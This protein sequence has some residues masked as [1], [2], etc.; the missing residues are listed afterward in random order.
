MHFRR[1]LSWFLLP[2]TLA[3]L[4]FADTQLVEQFDTLTLSFAG[5]AT[6]EQA[7]VNP[8]TDTRL[9]VTFTH[10]ERHY[11]IR[12]F[13]AAD[14]HAAET[15]ADSGPIWQVRFT[16]DRIGAWTYT[17]NLHRG[18]DIALS[19]D[20]QVGESL[21]LASPSGHFTVIPSTATG[22]DFRAHGRLIADGGFFRFQDTDN[23]WLK[24][25]TDSPENLLAFIDFDGTYRYRTEARQGE[26]A[27]QTE[28]HSYPTHMADWR[29]GDPTWQNGKGKALIGGLNYLA[30][31]G[32]NVAYFLTMNIG[33]DGKDVWPF[34]DHETFDR[35]D[36]SKL[37]QWEI[38]FQHMS[39]RGIMLHVVTQETENE[40]LLDGGDTGRL[41]QLYYRELIARFS[42]HLA[43][44][45]NL[46]EENGPADFS[47]DG[48]TAPQQRAMATYFKAHD[49]YQH[50]V[51]I[52]THSH[53]TQKEKGL[54]PLLNHPPLDGLSF[55][56][57]R[58]E[59]VHEAVLHWKQRARDAGH[60]WMITM[61]EIGL[62][63]TGAVPDSVDPSHDILRHHVL[64][65]SLLAGAAGVEWY[66]G[67]HH[68]HN[69]LSAEDWRTR[70]NLWF[71]TRIAI[72][73]LSALP[74]AHMRPAD[75][76]TPRTDDY[77]LA[78]PGQTYV[79]YAPPA[80]PPHIL[81]LQDHPDP[82]E[83]L[84]LD[85]LNDQPARPG[86]Q[87]TVAGPGPVDLGAPPNET[88]HDWVI[89]VRRP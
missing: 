72:D 78:T 88:E 19:N 1:P 62:W 2:L 3:T 45:W 10:A 28:L 41:R 16:P 6:A 75:E 22:R 39:R 32:M 59:T 8:F 87:P 68:A 20:L 70:H 86:S 77:V 73:F 60:E 17:A 23:Y 69:D 64:W 18:P 80:A 85:P 54:P 58:R 65:G 7:A 4:C 48:Q 30:D 15:S 53:D 26:A 51:L 5:P 66:F 52:H 83:V 84:W 50:P 89:L 55:Q 61:D 47:P 67:A 38:V 79:L 33:G 71:Q 21:P 63:H 43:L 11:Q 34:I 76:L 49:P 14:G 27:P 13:F 25:G 31:S 35:F 57:D 24:G 42:H 56:V 37:D 40:R 9:L 46:G 29:P 12:G 82:F 74:F 44:V 81:D 36:C